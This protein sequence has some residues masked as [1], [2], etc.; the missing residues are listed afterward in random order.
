MTRDI[1]QAMLNAVP[2]YYRENVEAKE[3][4]RLDAV[5]LV[6]CFTDMQ[7]AYREFTPSTAV[8]FMANWENF[9]GL[10]TDVN[11]PLEQRR[12]AVI[13]R[14]RGVGTVNIPMIKSVA[15]SFEF[16]TV[17]VTEDNPHYTITV[18]F[19]DERGMP[20]N[21]GDIHFALREIV[22]A[23]IDIKY[24]FTITI[25]NEVRIIWATYDELVAEGLEYTGIL[26]RRP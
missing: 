13:A 18:E 1:N 24:K 9:V 10:P 4:L 12:S 21:L 14:I 17:E 7:E 3:I 20:P 22:P 23:H 8:E 16:G 19:V 11:K 2:W 25:Y 26:Y 6:K 5:E 15:E